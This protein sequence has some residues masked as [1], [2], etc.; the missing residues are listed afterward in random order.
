ADVPKSYSEVQGLTITFD[1]RVNKNFDVGAKARW[2][3]SKFGEYV[4]TLVG[5]DS[6]A[7]NS[8]LFPPSTWL[9][10]N[11]FLFQEQDEFTVNPYA[12]LKFDAGPTSNVVV[13]GGDYSRL[14]DKGILT[15]DTFLG[16]VGVVDLTNPSFP[17]PYV[18][19]GDTPFTTFQKPSNTYET[20]G[21]YVQ[22]QTS[23]HNRLHL[24]A[25]VRLA[26]ISIDTQDPVLGLDVQSDTTRVL[27]RI[28]GVL[29]V[30]PGVSVYASYS[31]GLK[32]NPFT[33]FLGPPEPKSRCK[34]KP[35]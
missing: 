26:N 31:E 16:G 15:A 21:L 18:Q 19:P 12:R 35:A 29:D 11:A 6:F 20:S 25:G 17:F 32:A 24:L 7:A 2:S 28:G 23:I 4:Q 1:H 9:L 34:R 22:L 27:P 30:I 5:A 14:T 8:P 3:H 13:V 33:I 10:S